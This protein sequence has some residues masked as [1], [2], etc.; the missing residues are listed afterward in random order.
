MDADGP[1]FFHA[2]AS[3]VSTLQETSICLSLL[4]QKQKYSGKILS[5]PYAAVDALAPCVARRL[6][7]IVLNMED[8]N[9]L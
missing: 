1:K 9:I 8:R 4:I 2:K 3:A 7:V 5:K 6:P